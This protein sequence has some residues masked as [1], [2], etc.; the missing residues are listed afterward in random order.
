M[1]TF[2]D[3]IKLL[4]MLAFWGAFFG[5]IIILPTGL[6]DIKPKQQQSPE[7]KAD[8]DARFQSIRPII[9]R[10]TE[11]A[12]SLIIH[13]EIVLSAT[14]KQFYRGNVCPEKCDIYV[15]GY[16]WADELSIINPVACLKIKHN[17]LLKLV[18]YATGC[19]DAANDR[20]S[21]YKER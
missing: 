12:D 11:G 3:I 19:I 20:S 14:G 5:F 1:N 17:I 16:T 10:N 8:I 2:V 4:L 21:L 6:L 15:A 18:D 13:Y 7:Q 9:V